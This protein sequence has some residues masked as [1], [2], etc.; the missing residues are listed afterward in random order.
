M[1]TLDA[2]VLI[3]RWDQFD[4]THERAV[5]VLDHHEWDEFITPAVTLAEV[6]VRPVRRAWADQYLRRIDALGVLVVP[7]E[8][9]DA[10][11]IA[12]LCAHHR[13]AIPD[14]VALHTA[15]MTSDALVTFDAKLA[16][17]ARAIGFP[18]IDRAP[19][20]LEWDAPWAA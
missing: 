16:R 4:S 9:D 8:D 14:A 19:D 2:N 5:E 1:I 13:L 18:V 10:A 11:G 20:D 15:M 7:V 6:L 3:A 12:S 17:V